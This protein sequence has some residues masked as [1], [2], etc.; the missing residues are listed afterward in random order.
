MM[1]RLT[2]R[3]RIWYFSYVCRHD[4][5]RIGVGL[6]RMLTDVGGPARWTFERK[7][8]LAKRE[9]AFPGALVAVAA[10]R[11][12]IANRV[13]IARIIDSLTERQQARIHSVV[14]SIFPLRR[15]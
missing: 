9:S 1:D 13:E 2:G 8:M 12:K 10:S 5:E 7:L 6:R 14:S 11:W 3:I 4:P 15:D